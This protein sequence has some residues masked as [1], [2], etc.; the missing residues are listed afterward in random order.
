VAVSSQ[1]TKF[2]NG[3]GVAPEPGSIAWKLP[4][5]IHPLKIGTVFTFKVNDDEHPD[6]RR[7]QTL[8]SQA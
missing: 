1:V 6:V 5:S 3:K 7:H 4:Y 2:P 8:D